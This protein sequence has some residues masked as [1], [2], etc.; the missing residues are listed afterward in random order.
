MSAT[1]SMATLAGVPAQT[2]MRR[3][4]RYRHSTQSIIARLS[5][6]TAPSEN[7]SGPPAYTTGEKT[8]VTDCAPRPQKYMA[9]AAARTTPQA[10]SARPGVLRL[11]T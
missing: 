9:A 3:R 8:E 11:N 6:S 7:S 2:H 10:I 1:V 5:S 4:D